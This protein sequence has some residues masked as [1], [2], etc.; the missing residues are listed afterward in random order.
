MLKVGCIGAGATGKTTTLKLLEPHVKESY[1]PGVM[2]SVLKDLAVH[3]EGDQ[4]YMDPERTW[5]VQKTGF[6]RKIEQDRN[7]DHGLFDRTLLDHFVYCMLWARQSIDDS[8]CKSMMI[9][10]QENL[11]SYDR[12]FYFPIYDWSAPLDP[13]RENSYA[14][15]IAWDF[16]ARGLLEDLGFSES[17][18]EVPDD[19]PVSRAAYLALCMRDS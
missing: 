15:R 12:L 8:T 5:T 2:R 3:S 1:I 4:K 6:D 13:I 18:K 17:Y 14:S 9:L 16:M 11:R 10:V 7:H 19:D